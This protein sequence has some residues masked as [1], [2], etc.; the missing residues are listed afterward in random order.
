MANRSHLYTCDE[1]PGGKG[2]R[3]RGLSE[4]GW[5]IPLV[6][7]LMVAANPHVVRS[8]IWE[9]DI[10]IIADREGAFDR[11]SAFFDKLGEGDLGDRKEF[12]EELAQMKEFLATTPPSKYILLE[13]GEILDLMGEDLNK[14]VADLHAEIP[15]VAARAAAA[16][17]GEE[18][19]WLAE[20]RSEWAE[21][22]RPGYWSDILYY[23]FDGTQSAE[24]SDAV[25]DGDDDDN[26]DETPA[27]KPAA[28][29]AKAAPKQP[30]PANNA[31]SA[32]QSKPA[33]VKPGAKKPAAKKPAAKKPAAKKP[34]AKKPAA[35][36]SAAK[37]PA[38][39]KR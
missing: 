19:A 15:D 39:K 18:D 25:D 36:K 26:D 30:A 33:E 24:S 28:K 5:E 4:Y 6:H 3:A 8:A 27:A 34:A 38:K 22:A 35:K 37:K 7:K 32:K 1:I 12:D 21:K 29:P 16:V 23:S 9:H 10:A 14:L 11:A 20:L 31:A 13:A 2:F 17:A